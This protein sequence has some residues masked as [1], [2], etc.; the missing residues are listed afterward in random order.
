MPIA[1]HPPCDA[2]EQ[3]VLRHSRH[4]PG[5]AA[6]QIVMP[7]R[8]R[9]TLTAFY[10]AATNVPGNG[11]DPLV[12]API[13]RRYGG[14]GDAPPEALPR[15]HM[16]LPLRV[17]S[18]TGCTTSQCSTILSSSNLQKSANMRPRSFGPTDMK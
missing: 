17:S 1:E 8:M 14:C 6:I 18:G 4:E 7:G 2:C 16:G 9:G 5:N 11:V 12:V 10:I 15:Y 3:P 13:L